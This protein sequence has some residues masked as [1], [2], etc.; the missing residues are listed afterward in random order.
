MFQ[1][2]KGT[3]TFF[4]SLMRVKNSVRT[5]WASSADEL[6]DRYYDNGSYRDSLASNLRRLYPNNADEMLKNLLM[7]NVIRR[8]VDTKAKLYRSPP[9]RKLKEHGDESDRTAYDKASALMDKVYRTARADVKLKW[10]NRYYELLNSAVLW[11]QVGPDGMPHLTVLPAHQLLVEQGSGDSESLQAC[12]EIYVPL[13]S[14]AS[15]ISPQETSYLRY[16]RNADGFVD[17]AAVNASLADLSQQPQGLQVYSKMRRY[18]FVVVRKGLSLD[19][20]V[21]SDV[22]H[23]LLTSAR[24]IDHELTRGALNSRHADFP[25]Y[26][27]NGSREELGSVNPATGAGAIICLG[28]DEKRLEPLGIES[29]EKQRNDNLHFFLRMLAQSCDIS[30]SAFSYEPEL[31]SGVAKFHDKQPEIEY[32][33][34][35][36]PEWQ[37]ME[38]QDLWPLMRE[39]L[40]IGAVEGADILADYELSVEYPKQVVA[41]SRK[42]QLD[43]LQKEFE[44]GL[45]SPVDELASSGNLGRKEAEMRYK[46][47]LENVELA[48]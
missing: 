3:A 43:N 2:T 21:F 16:R 42:E 1:K 24:W 19:G 7:L 45:S 47:N 37:S 22:P 26:T 34:E 14:S 32:R 9:R 38:E 4:E 8:I 39:L 15:S 6:L 29:R 33:E 17:V 35:L 36:I 11:G 31:L 25:A 44:L 10:L 40:K 23:G 13:S 20:E 28:D 5:E 18:P 41:L 48:K 12:K 27:Y 30:P 46:A